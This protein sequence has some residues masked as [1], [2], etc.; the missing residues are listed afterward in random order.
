MRTHKNYII[1]G[2][3]LL[4]AGIL[5]CS[6]SIFQKSET[7]T[8]ENAPTEVPQDRKPVVPVRV[9]ATYTSSDIKQG[10]VKGDWAIEQVNGKQAIGETAPFIK[11][12]P[13]QGRVYGNNGCN[14][15]NGN[16]KYS[17]ADHSITFTGLIT[18]MMACRP[19]IPDTEINAA[20]NAVTNYR[21]EQKEHQY[22]MYLQNADGETVLVLMHQNF[23]FLNGTWLVQS[24]KNKKINVKNKMLV[25]D[26]K[27]VIDVPE[28]K[29]HGNT[30]C[31]ILNGALNVDMDRPN[32]ISFEN[33]ATTRMACPPDNN[34]ETDLL[35]ALEEATTAH[36]VDAN[37][38]ELL[39]SQRNVIMVLVRTSNDA[40]E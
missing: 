29:V 26:M 39:N 30:G 2:A 14:T 23:D 31:N 33:L 13:I 3:S 10:I 40:A 19:D 12:E 18:T 16:Y 32:S 17:V 5:T 7:T 27:L 11:F 38:V 35:V 1:Y 24:I 4:T 6:C 22:W 9:S 21:I 25:P 20:L 34:Y 28:G 37:T 36:P 8:V 15:L